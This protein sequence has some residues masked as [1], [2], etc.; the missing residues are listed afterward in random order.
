M[1]E[2]R[3][4]TRYPVQLEATFQENTEP[5][6]KCMVSDVSIEGIRLLVPEKIRFGQ[7]I[8][9]IIRIPNTPEAVVTRMTVRWTR[10][11]YKQGQVAY[12]AGGELSSEDD[13][14]EI[15]V[16][17]GSAAQTMQ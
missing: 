5:P 9:L 8:T 17:Y 7:T 11:F 2:R 15:L 12:I 1:D 3:K 16:R 14:G 10:P 6:R 13:A 4:F